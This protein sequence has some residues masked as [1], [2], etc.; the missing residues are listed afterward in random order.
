MRWKIRPWYKSQGK[1]GGIILLSEVITER[2]NAED[3]PREP[4]RMLALRDM[5]YGFVQEHKGH[6]RCYNEP[7]YGTTFKICFPSRSTFRY[8]YD[9]VHSRLNA[10]SHCQIKGAK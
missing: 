10:T 8:G 3:A 4:E 9:S 7:G 6:I 5:V 1:I 2:K